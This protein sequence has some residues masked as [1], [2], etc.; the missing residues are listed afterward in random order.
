MNSLVKHHSI[1]VGAGADPACWTDHLPKFVLLRKLVSREVSAYILLLLWNWYA[2]HYACI[3]FLWAGV[4]SDEFSICNG[5]RQG[6]I[7]LHYITLQIFK[8]A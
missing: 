8:V 5:V 4:Q 6:A 1:L 2:H 7:Q 3:L